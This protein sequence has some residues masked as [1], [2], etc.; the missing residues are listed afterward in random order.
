[1]LTDRQAETDGHTDTTK[2]TVALRNFVTALNKN[3][4][5]QDRTGVWTPRSFYNVIIT[6][7]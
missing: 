1:M 3:E 4:S 6:V 7:C 2:L 5:T